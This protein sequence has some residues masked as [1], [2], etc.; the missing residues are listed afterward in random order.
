MGLLA[1]AFS[2]VLLFVTHVVLW[3]V[4]CGNRPNEWGENRAELCGGDTSRIVTAIVD[5]SVF[6]L[7]VSAVLMGLI[8]GAIAVTTSCGAAQKVRSVWLLAS[9]AVYA[10]TIAVQVAQR[11]LPDLPLVTEMPYMAIKGVVALLVWLL[12]T[13]PMLLIA[14][15][16]RRGRS[17]AGKLPR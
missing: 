17:A 2:A 5:T 9:A 14:R 3:R 7:V 12:V 10:G 8:C 13:A 16:M 6:V 4:V 11:V 1:G 15:A